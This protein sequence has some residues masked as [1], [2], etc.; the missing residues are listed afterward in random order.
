MT[1]VGDVFRRYYNISTKL[2]HFDDTPVELI[3]ESSGRVGLK[4]DNRF[5][6]QDLLIALAWRRMAPDSN[7]RA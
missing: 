1:K 6:T 5:V 3:I 2:W 4:M 7:E